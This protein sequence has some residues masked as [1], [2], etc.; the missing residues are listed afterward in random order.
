MLS[1][2]TRSAVRFPR[3][4]P[5]VPKWNGNGRRLRTIGMGVSIIDSLWVTTVVPQAR[6]ESSIPDFQNGFY[7][8]PYWRSNGHRLC[9]HIKSSGSTLS[10]P[11]ISVP[12]VLTSPF[13]HT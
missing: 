3:L 13:V 7:M 5:P 4:A 10:A 2:R 8:R 12:K 9:R 6:R 1:I 11:R